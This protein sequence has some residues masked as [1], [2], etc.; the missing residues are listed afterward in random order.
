MSDSQL[1]DDYANLAVYAE[2]AEQGRLPV[3]VYA[4]PSITGVDD[5]AKIGVRRAFGSPC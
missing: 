5:F 2:L 1:D 3:R 4:A